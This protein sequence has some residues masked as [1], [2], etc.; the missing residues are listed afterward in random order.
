MGN[1]P[2]D[3]CW[4]EVTSKCEEL[5][6]GTTTMAPP[7][8]FEDH[9]PFVIEELTS[10]GISTALYQSFYDGARPP[11]TD[12]F[13]KS[14]APLPKDGLFMARGRKFWRVRSELGMALG[15]NLWRDFSGGANLADQTDY[16]RN[17]S[18]SIA[19]GL[20]DLYV[21]FLFALHRTS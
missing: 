11:V 12:A 7:P 8:G 18:T 9:P 6:W 14:V 1:L 2:F 4:F 16:L 5:T 10:L 20:E 15:I 3:Y 17:I 19:T 21:N 13:L